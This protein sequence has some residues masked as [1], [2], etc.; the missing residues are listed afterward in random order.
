MFFIYSLD[1]KT[2]SIELHDCCNLETEVDTLLDTVV[3]NFIRVEEGE[4]KATNPFKDDVN[5]DAITEDG[6]FLRHSK[7]TPRQ[8]Y[9]HHRKSQVLPGRVWNSFN[10]EY[11][12]KTVYGVTQLEMES[13]PLVKNVIVKTPAQPLDTKYSDHLA[14]LKERL[15]LQKEK[16]D[17]QMKNLKQTTQTTQN[18]IWIS[19]SFSDTET[20]YE[21]PKSRLER[22]INSE[23]VSDTETDSEYDCGEKY[24][25]GADIDADIDEDEDEEFSRVIET[26]RKN[27]PTN[28][29]I[30]EA[31]KFEKEEFERLP[32]KY[33]Y[34][35]PLPPSP[36]SSAYYPPPPT[37]SP[38]PPPP[39]T[40]LPPPPPPP[41]PPAR[42]FR[43]F[44]LG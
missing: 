34:L 13:Q 38:S 40:S 28:K 21:G 5:D 43:S 20:D 32:V 3:R 41:P 37:S 6:Y 26:L 36:L 14:K 22:Y 11:E 30:E 44:S 42:P 29:L 33:D 19:Q 8:V 12:R 23:H 9:V 15:I 4:K 2:L 7:D 24:F 27:G 17:N 39:P 10:V 18:N 1:L 25:Y 31:K 35:F 16:V